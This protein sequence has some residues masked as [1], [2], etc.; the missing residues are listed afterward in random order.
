MSRRVIAAILTALTFSAGAANTRPNII[1]INADDLGVMDVGY[2]S[3]RYRTPNLDRL[4]KEGMVFTE[5]YAP[6]ANCAPSRA[7]VISG[8]YGPRHGV[9]TVMNSDRGKAQHRKL[10]PIKNTQHLADEMLT[11]PEVLKA[12]GYTT[13]H[14]GKWHLGEDPC[15][16]GFD[17]NVGGGTSGSPY[18][19]YFVPFKGPMAKYNELG[20]GTHSGDIFA[21]KAIEFLK[22]HGDEPFF[23]HMAYYLVHSPIQP[24]P[25][26][27]DKYKA[28][29]DVNAAYASMIEKMD[30][31]IG[32]IISQLD[33]MGLRENTLVLFTS[34][35]GGVCK[36]SSQKP[37]RAGKG[38]Y[39]EGGIRE[40][41]WVRWPTK[42]KA[43]TTCDVP[44][45]GIDFFPTFLGAAG[46]E[47]PKGKELDGESLMSLLTG[48]DDF[49]GR[50]LFWHFPIYLQKYGGVDDDAHDPLFRTRPGSAMRLGKW[51]LHEYFEDGRLELYDLDADIG[52]RT[53]LAAKMPG[54]AKELHTILKAWRK[55]TDAPVPTE[56]N[57]KY[58]EAADSTARKQAKR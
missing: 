26:M 52:E 48:K 3:D 54:K 8:Q 49:P 12:G 18:G 30:E 57:P 19:G 1:Y 37:Y 38:S 53:N 22:E 43:G 29:E 4:A 55:A 20:K 16:Q 58:D 6:S 2:N 10:I 40:P 7:C 56:P 39:F 50:P 41:M 45:C 34:D 17:Y 21:D 13:I 35:N 42:V 15:S 23:M 5:A 51:K 11:L 33:A 24:V 36:T 31:S 14:L 28:D 27:V 44:V 25:G 32:R 9:Y 46:L 47:V